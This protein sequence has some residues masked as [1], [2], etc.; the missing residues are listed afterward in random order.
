M[1]RDRW[2]FSHQGSPGTDLC[3]HL[4]MGA[5]GYLLTLF[6]FVCPVVLPHSIPATPPTILL[7]HPPL[8]I[9]ANFFFFFENG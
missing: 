8:L 5:S 1:A 6:L 3:K 9:T 2:I 7:P 4:D